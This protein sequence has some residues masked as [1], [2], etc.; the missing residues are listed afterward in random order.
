MAL[1]DLKEECRDGIVGGQ[2]VQPN[3]REVGPRGHHA[4]ESAEVLRSEELCRLS[5]GRRR[6]TF[7]STRGYGQ[8]DRSI[9][10]SK[11]AISQVC[12]ACNELLLLVNGR[13]R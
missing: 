9:K 4:L 13:W 1:L 6:E 5:E 7:V 3:V 12:A 2:G 10:W 11:R 8:K